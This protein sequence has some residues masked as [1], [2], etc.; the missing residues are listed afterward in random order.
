[1]QRLGTPEEVADV[2]L[3]LASAGRY[4]TGQNF[5]VDGGLFMR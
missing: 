3:Y 4:I 1:L 2:I 5:L